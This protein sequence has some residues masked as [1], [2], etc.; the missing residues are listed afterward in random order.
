MFVIVVTMELIKEYGASDS[1]EDSFSMLP[2]FFYNSKPVTPKGNSLSIVQ[3]KASENSSNE[4]R[5]NS[6]MSSIVSEDLDTYLGND[7]DWSRSPTPN[8]R[9]QDITEHGD[10]E[11]KS[12]TDI[13]SDESEHSEYV[14]SEDDLLASDEKSDE[15]SP[16]PQK[17]KENCKA[18]L[19]SQEVDDLQ[20]PKRM[21]SPN[22]YSTPKRGKK[23]SKPKSPMFGSSPTF[24]SPSPMFGSPKALTS[25]KARQ[26]PI[27]LDIQIDDVKIYV[28]Q[29]ATCLKENYKDNNDIKKYLDD[30]SYDHISTQLHQNNKDDVN[31]R[32]YNK[33]H[34]C[35]SCGKCVFKMGRHFFK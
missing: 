3:Y 32:R 28:G 6:Q 35:Y 24:G 15:D 5:C 17:N 2:Q 13:S 30:P 4:D 18:K 10:I 8:N 9:E 27:R 16:K 23:C 7:M 21:K 11:L 20:S 12:D 25:P 34:I 19:N 26:S 14:P 31:R 33:Y 29:V 1:E 22:S